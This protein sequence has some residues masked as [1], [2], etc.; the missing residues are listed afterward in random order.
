MTDH[1]KMKQKLAAFVDNELKEPERKTI[2]EH[3]AQCSSCREEVA[4]IQNLHRLAKES[5][6]KPEP[7]FAVNLSQQVWR[8]I[9]AKEAEP[10]RP[11]VRFFSIPR[12]A[13]ILAGAV[14]VLLVVI[15]GIRLFGT[16]SGNNKSKPL[17]IPPSILPMAGLRTEPVQPKTEKTEQGKEEIQRLA[18]KAGTKEMKSAEYAGG[19]AAT[20]E[21][22]AASPPAIS[23]P[24]TK[25]TGTGETREFDTFAAQAPKESVQKEKGII[26]E[27]AKKGAI[28]TATLPEAS[29]EKAKKETANKKLTQSYVLPDNSPE[30]IDIPEAEYPKEAQEKKL[31]GTVFIKA[32][33]D[34]DG[35]VGKITIVK[36][37]G[38]GILDSAALKAAEKSRYKPA[39]Q[40]RHKVREWVAIMFR[41]PP[42]EK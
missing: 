34:T 14:V 37:S 3:L 13:P 30:V 6:P 7:D 8:K 40:N 41:F 31:T 38:Y 42:K 19:A 9:R 24:T 10:V 33:V 32:L 2:E 20:K 28:P 1:K 18:E 12:I 16:F 17:L 5:A 26:M 36:S 11:K 25:G 21:A 4:L 15:V 27:E 39:L 29:L 23:Q 22:K 35:T